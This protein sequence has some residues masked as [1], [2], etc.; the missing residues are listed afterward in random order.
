[1][2]IALQGNGSVLA[3]SISIPSHVAGDLIMIHAL[4]GVSAT[5]PVKPS[6]D[7]IT[8]FSASASGG[9]VLIA[10]LH[11]RNSST[12]SGTWTN[13]DQL[14]VTVWRGGANSIVVPEFMSTQTATAVTIAYA[15][16]T[17]GSFKTD[18]ANVA[19]LAYVVNNNTT[20][21]LL[22]PGALTNLQQAT[23]SSTW[24]AK[25]FYQLNRTTV[26]ASTNS[27]QAASAFYRTLMLALVE[28][29][30]YGISGGGTFDPLDHP[31]IK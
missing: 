17:A 24:Q 26:W 29:D 21:T 15:A 4:N 1:M 11:A 9:S 19:F 12:V 6:T 7:W 30:L 14:F 16:Q 13:A 3:D 31:L 2:T 22:P 20:N 25:Q 28:S 27:T 23:D 5:L 18:A 8:S 10:Y